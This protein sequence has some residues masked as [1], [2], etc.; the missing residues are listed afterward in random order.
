MLYPL[1]LN[2]SGINVFVKVSRT[3]MLRYSIL[4]VESPKYHLSAT[5][6]K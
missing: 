6:S 5:L 3:F 2:C 4:L 1:V